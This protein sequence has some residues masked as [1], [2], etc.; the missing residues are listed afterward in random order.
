MG[1]SSAFKLVK[2]DIN[3]SINIPYYGK[4]YSKSGWKVV[5]FF[6]QKKTCKVSKKI[7]IISIIIIIITII[8]AI[9]II[10][11]IIII[12]NSFYFDFEIGH[13]I[14]ALQIDQLINA[15]VLT[16]VLVNSNKLHY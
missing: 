12:I 5:N 1:K 8:I 15:K 2:T 9:I 3:V 10:I 16:P 11:I 7:N 4:Y 14:K 13:N 6:L